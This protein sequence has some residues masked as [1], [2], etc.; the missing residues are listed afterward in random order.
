MLLELLPAQVFIK[1]KTYFFE[2]SKEEDTGYYVV[3]YGDEVGKLLCSAVH[4]NS[5]EAAAKVLI[6]LLTRYD[7]S[8][9]P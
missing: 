9:E 7:I 5:A 3:Q 4:R 1:G 8:L 2:L 6:T